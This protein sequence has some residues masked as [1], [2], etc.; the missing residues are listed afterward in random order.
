MTSPSVEGSRRSR[1]QPGANGKIKRHIEGDGADDRERIVEGI[2]NDER[3]AAK[4]RSRVDTVVD[5]AKVLG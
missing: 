4:T 3:D 5:G 2:G 1:E